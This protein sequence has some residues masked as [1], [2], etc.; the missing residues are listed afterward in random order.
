M[1]VSEFWEG[2]D[3]VFGATLG[4]SYASDLYLTSLCG[5][6]EEALDRGVAPQEVWEALVDEA[7]VDP[8]MKW[9][10]RLDQKERR[11]SRS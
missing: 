11:R 4:R 9:I 8:S 7:G 1:K 2:V 5:T 6:C 3:A 10:H